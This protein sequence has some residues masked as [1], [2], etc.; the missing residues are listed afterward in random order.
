MSSKRPASAVLLRTNR[1]LSSTAIPHLGEELK[2]FSPFT[3]SSIARPRDA[4]KPAF[5]FRW[6]G[7][8]TTI[9]TPTATWPMRIGL[10]GPHSKR[11]ILRRRSVPPLPK[12][13]LPA[14]T[15]KTTN[16]F[17]IDSNQPDD[18]ELLVAGVTGSV[19]K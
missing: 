7:S 1:E 17:F 18:T 3:H 4:M 8:A 12:Q 10:T 16:L 5:H 9:A 13:T 2:I 6:P 11:R 14:A 19:K 15:A